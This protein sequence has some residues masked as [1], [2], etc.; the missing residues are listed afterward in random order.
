MIARPDGSVDDHVRGALGRLAVIA[1]V[2]MG[3]EIDSIPGCREG[4]M[5]VAFDAKA[6]LK[7]ALTKMEQKDADEEMARATKK[8]KREKGAALA[9]V[10]R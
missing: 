2:C 8:I 10:R 6:E 4:L 7:A 9:R 1:A 5:H 3:D